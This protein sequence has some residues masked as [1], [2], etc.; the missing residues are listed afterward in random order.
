[1]TL[2][3]KLA[4]T[5]E[6]VRELFAQTFTIGNLSHLTR[7]MNMND[8][9]YTFQWDKRSKRKLGCCNYSFQR[10]TLSVHYV[11][12]N[13]EDKFYLIEDT[14][15]HEM[16]HAFS[17]E[18][19]GSR[20]GRGHGDH[21]KFTCKQVGADPTRT[22]SDVNM[23]YK[24]SLVCPSCGETRANYHRKP[25]TNKACGKCCNEH[26]NGQYDAQYKLELRENNS[27]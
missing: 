14:I 16:A 20:L 3:E 19:Y 8:L 1:M 6:K 10:I 11:D 25:K 12:Q 26:N 27:K 23:T 5:E 18:F 4:K 13:F 24:Y 2:Q 9:G 21:W 15:R 7:D 22:K 17:Y